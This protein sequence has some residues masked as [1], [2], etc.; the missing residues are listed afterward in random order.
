VQMAGDWSN[1]RVLAI[2]FDAK[3]GLMSGAASP[4]LETG[5]AMGW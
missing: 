3:S 1:G 5:Y 4:R 2:R